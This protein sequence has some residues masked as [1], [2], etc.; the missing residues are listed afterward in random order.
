MI[1]QLLFFLEKM[2]GQILFFL[3]KKLFRTFLSIKI[4]YIRAVF[5]IDLL[6]QVF[7]TKLGTRNCLFIK[8]KPLLKEKHRRAGTKSRVRADQKHLFFTWPNRKSS[9]VLCI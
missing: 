4:K 9:L 2:I 1:G 7:K 8:K 5:L 3:R 6:L